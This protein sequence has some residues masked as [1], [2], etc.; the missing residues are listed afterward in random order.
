MGG[1]VQGFCADFG[2]GGDCV[3]HEHLLCDTGK[4]R[5]WGHGWE[6]RALLGFLLE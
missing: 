5:T 1:Y 6:E 3:A 2:R 4:T